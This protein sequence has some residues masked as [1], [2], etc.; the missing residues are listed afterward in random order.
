[1]DPEKRNLVMLQYWFPNSDGCLV[2]LQENVFAGEKTHYNIQ[3]YGAT[4]WQF[5]FKW[6][7]KKLFALCL[8]N[9]CEFEIVLNI[10][11][12]K[13]GNLESTVKETRQVILGKGR[14]GQGRDLLRRDM[15]KLSGVID[16]N[17]LYLGWSSGYLDVYSSQNLS[18]CVFK[19]CAPCYIIP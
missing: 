3:T 16:G 7:K 5:N 18:D 11:G 1:M 9:F 12:K 13:T 10:G 17:V 15:R 6:F 2:V 14:A 8:Q 19:I 4:C